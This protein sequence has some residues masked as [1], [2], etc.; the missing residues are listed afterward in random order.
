MQLVMQ[1]EGLLKKDTDFVLISGT[2]NPSLHEEIARL[3]GKPLFPTEIVRFPDGEIRVS[4]KEVIE[5]KKA[6]ILQSL[7][8]QPNEY[9]VETFLIG[10]A[11]RRAGVTHIGLIAPYLA[12][13]RQS[14]QEENGTSLASRLFAYF[15]HEAGIQE[16]RTLDL[17][18]EH[19]PSFYDFPVHH[20]SALEVLVEAFLKQY[21]SDN[22]VVVGPDLGSAKLVGRYAEKLNRDFALVEKRRID[23][24]NVLNLSIVGEVEGKDVLLAD[25]MCSTAGTL[26]SAAQLCREKG[27]KRIFAAVTHG[28]FVERALELIEKSPIEH[29]FVTNSVPLDDSVTQCAKISCVSCAPL[30]V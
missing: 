27:A 25:D 26:A 17:H 11:L 23:A 20:F 22:L 16:M 12:Y 3:S 4:F 1:K 15:L 29:L 24:R 9:L 18:A 2:S 28:L 5:A 7:G 14:L 10:D 13:S 8:R 6:V 19:I 21:A 30:L